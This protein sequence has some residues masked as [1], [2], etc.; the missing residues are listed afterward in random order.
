VQAAAL[1]FAREG[2]RGAR[3]ADVALEAGLGKGTVYEY[4][5]SKEELF[6][7]V[8]EW[9]SRKMESEIMAKIEALD[10]SRAR[11]MELGEEAIRQGLANLEL[12]GLTLEFWAAAGT[13]VCEG[14]F[15]QAFQEVYRELRGEVEA[16]IEEGQARGELRPEVPAGHVAATLV[17]ALDALVLQH[18]FD[19]DLDPLASAR[20]FLDALIQGMVSDATGRRDG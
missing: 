18:W 7:A 2:F 4:F 8:F 3:I 11:L 13:G 19:P 20:G 17:G 12:Y 6:F 1:V 5:R 10:S 16:I 9:S 14:R 15:R